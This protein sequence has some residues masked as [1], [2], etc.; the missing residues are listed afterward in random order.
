MT[1]PETK[2]KP[3]LQIY[4]DDDLKSAIQE[5]ANRERMS[6]TTWAIQAI[7]NYL[8]ADIAVKVER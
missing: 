1:E 8:P 6:M 5:A 3:L 4:M 7:L 2:R